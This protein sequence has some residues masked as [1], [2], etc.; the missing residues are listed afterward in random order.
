MEFNVTK[1]D[2]TPNPSR[3]AAYQGAVTRQLKQRE[4]EI[5]E[6]W[7]N[8]WYADSTADANSKSDSAAITTEGR[9]SCL[10]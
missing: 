6:T 9:W 10:R 1:C 2:S 7:W 3:T 8:H 5:Q 4:C